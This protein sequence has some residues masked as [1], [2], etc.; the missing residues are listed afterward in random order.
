[1]RKRAATTIGHQRTIP[2]WWTKTNRNHHRVRITTIEGSLREVSRY[3][4]DSF[5]EL[6]PQAQCVGGSSWFVVETA[7]SEKRARVGRPTCRNE[8]STGS[9]FLLALWERWVRVRS[10]ATG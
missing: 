2:K 4:N 10:I 6:D 5:T 3:F 1:L 7:T 9:G 8:V